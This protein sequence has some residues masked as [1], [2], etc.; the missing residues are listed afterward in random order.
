MQRQRRRRPGKMRGIGGSGGRQFESDVVI[1]L[2][3]KISS[4]RL[5]ERPWHL[6]RRDQV[7]EGV[8][9]ERSTDVK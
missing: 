9:V 5:S 3:P 2:A 4:Y 1:V 8:A 7:V 6:S